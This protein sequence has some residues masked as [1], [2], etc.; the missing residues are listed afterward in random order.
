MDELHRSIFESWD[1]VHIGLLVWA[2]GATI[3]AAWSLG[4]AAQINRRTH[5]LARK[6]FLPEARFPH[7][8]TNGATR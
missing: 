4:K 5:D 2:T 7:S 3:L 6:S 8:E 1:V